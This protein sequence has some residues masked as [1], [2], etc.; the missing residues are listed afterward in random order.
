MPEIVYLTNYTYTILLPTVQ[1]II[2]KNEM[3]EV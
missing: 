2:S 3:G 1:G